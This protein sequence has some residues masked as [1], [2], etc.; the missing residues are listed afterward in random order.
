[1]NFNTTP[2]TTQPR[3][4]QRNVRTIYEKMGISSDDILIGDRL[5][6]QIRP[7]RAHFVVKKKE[8]MNDNNNTKGKNT[9]VKVQMI[10]GYDES[11]LRRE[12][13]IKVMGTSED[14]VELEHRE[15]LSSL[16]VGGTHVVSA[17]EQKSRSCFFVGSVCC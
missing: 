17:G 3:Q 8:T 7:P 4:L 15:R 6:A 11:R 14:E 1:M 10:F 13:A 12:K 2:T 5:M 9:I 16:G